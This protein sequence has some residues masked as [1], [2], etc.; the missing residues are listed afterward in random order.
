LSSVIAN[1]QLNR[2][3]GLPQRSFYPVVFQL[4]RL[5]FFKQ[6][7]QCLT[8]CFQQVCS[9]TSSKRRW[10]KFIYM[11]KHIEYILWL[12]FD[13]EIRC[14]MRAGQSMMG[15]QISELYQSKTGVYARRLWFINNTPQSHVCAK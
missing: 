4:S 10:Q 12:W 5:C 15:N 11:K 13:L 9:S 14:A 6:V 8:A 1:L 3:P 2:V 7:S